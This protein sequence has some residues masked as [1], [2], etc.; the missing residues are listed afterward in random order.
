MKVRQKIIYRL[1]AVFILFA[2][3]I[4]VPFSLSVVNHVQKM[5]QEEED[6]LDR[7]GVHAEYQE[8]H[9]MFVP[10]LVEQM[11]PYAFYILVLAFVLSIFFM[12]RML[13]ALKNL[14]RG[15]RELRD[16]NLGVRL[17]VVSQDELGRVTEA[18]N[19]MATVLQRKTAELERKDT[20]INAMLDPLWVVDD[21][22]RIV[23]VNPAFTRL[24]GY[25]RGEVV[26]RLVFDLLDSRDAAILH[27][28]IEEKRSRGIAS[29]YEMNVRRK[30]GSQIPV[31]V[32]GAPVVEEGRVVAKIA[33][34]KDFR[35]QI[36][37][38]SELQQSLDYIETVMNSIEDALLVIDRNFR[39]V[40][41]NRVAT[42][43]ARSPL[44]GSG[45]H[46]MLHRSDKPC[47]EAGE[48]C[49]AQLVFATGETHQTTHRHFD[50]DGS[51]RAFEVVAS[52][53]KDAG[54][55]VLYVIELLRDVT[56]RMLQQE[57]IGRKNR[58]LTAI[59]GISA[60]LSRSLRPEEIFSK[61]LDRM[62]ELFRM[63]GGG[64]F[65]AEE[66]ARE[67]VCRYHR[68]I[69]EEY[70]RMLGRV[71]FGEDIPG[72]VAMSGEMMTSSDVSRDMRVD[73]SLVKHSGI[74]GYCCIPLRGKERVI[75]VLC[76]FSFS[77]HLFSREEETIL[78]S[79]GE[80]T[81]MAI[82][83]IRLYEK[84]R[85]LY[86]FQK[87]RRGDEH[88]RLLSLSSRLGA[89]TELKDVLGSAIGLIKDFSRADFAWLLAADEK[90]NLV[91]K[92]SSASGMQEQVVVYGGG[93]S[94]LEG[95]ALSRRAPVT[96]A[97]LSAEERFYRAPV[98]AGSSYQAAVAIP[99]VIGAK[100]VGV[101]ALYYAAPR[102]IRD[103]ELHFLEIV[104]N[105]L[106]VSLERSDYYA[107]AILE[108]GRS[109]AILQSVADGIITVDTSGAVISVN[110]AFERLVGVPSR[111]AVRGAL[112][113]VF[114]YREENR[115][116][117]MLLGECFDAALEGVSTSRNAVLLTAYGTRLDVVINSSP[118]PDL[119]GRVIGVVSLIRDVSRER[120][121][122]RMKTGIIRS[123]SHEFRTPLS[124]IVGMTEMILQ[125]DVEGERIGR[126]LEV[127][128]DEGVRLSKMVSELL[129]I[130]RIESGKES[131]RVA[132]VDLPGLV[133][134]V[135]QTFSSAIAA[136]KAILKSRF[137]DGVNLV[138]DEE[139]VLQLLMNLVDNALTFSDE[140]CIIDI[141][142]ES[143]GGQVC[144]RVSDTGWGIP[145]EDRPH[146]GEHFFRGR[147]GARTK[148]TGLGLALCS[149][150]VRMH[151][152]SLE[153]R[154][155]PGKGTEVE[156][157]LPILEAT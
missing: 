155:R 85:E 68:G 75:G 132:P 134:H 49:P 133:E 104:G 129:S 93:V 56:E 51:P 81:G 7:S 48:E 146:V 113:D 98:V 36:S 55:H 17:D 101:L 45:C 86:E 19:E 92:A 72:K 18:F 147:H 34:L 78:A 60:I 106:A 65:F 110:R 2:V 6:I 47:W 89:A 135:R 27:R 66:T 53:V 80:M 74:R 151:G 30:D 96:V 9:D 10:R 26:G 52:P 46:A 40:S 150:I 144:L 157:K 154:S 67:L 102:V 33:I 149:E 107:R 109:E 4:V 43:K 71:R 124:A 38:R 114:R 61:V 87:K 125:G 1:I 42:E 22:N 140:G 25:E 142:A 123:V 50:G 21:E 5:V 91:L 88:D 141:V 95:Y 94:S 32:S 139:K 70:V 99:L 83:N 127:V 24:F 122:D 76:L 64:I 54:G 15:S 156:V 29:S 137:D 12:R 105:V 103:E 3:M 79:I 13:V 128:R 31:L 82:E 62:I 111:K 16:G 152:G 117:R 59:N 115:D 118:V 23:D 14:E 138:A 148:G 131:L 97:Q 69:S 90:A 37:L 8:K 58:E 63:D 28:Q 130:A 100:P 121:V 77:V 126:Y 39:I 136:K 41:A 57:E 84:M 35:E 145:E 44:V 108:K 119:N 73:R 11:V 116:F 112:C 153:I 120:E 20:Y 143:E